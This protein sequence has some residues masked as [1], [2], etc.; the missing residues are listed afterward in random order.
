MLT[1]NVKLDPGSELT[2][3]EA[4]QALSQ[5]LL[6]RISALWDSW[7]ESGLLTLEDGEDRGRWKVN[8]TLVKA[9]AEEQRPRSP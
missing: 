9:D 6:P 1:L 3:E 4:Y 7:V 2:P 5:L 8:G